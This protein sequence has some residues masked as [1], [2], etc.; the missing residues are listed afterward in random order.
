MR[1]LLASTVPVTAVAGSTARTYADFAAPLREVGALLEARAVHTGRSARNHLLAMA[2]TKR[3]P[4]SRV[5]AMIGLVGLTTWRASASVASRSAWGNASDR[6]GAAGRPGT[7]LLD[8][9]VT[10]FD[11]RG[12]PVDPQ[13]AQVIAA[14][15]RTVFVSRT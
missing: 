15:G 10:A 6:L 12:H 8:E 4:R 1:L 14:E 13:P 5:D 9:P 11:P 2:A 3:D 7:L